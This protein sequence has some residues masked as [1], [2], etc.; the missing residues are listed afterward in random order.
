MFTFH[1]FPPLVMLEIEFT[2]RNSGLCLPD[3]RVFG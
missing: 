1:N 3:I 2:T